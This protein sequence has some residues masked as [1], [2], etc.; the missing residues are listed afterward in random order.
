MASTATS[1]IYFFEFVWLFLLQVANCCIEPEDFC[2]N[3]A[4]ECTNSSIIERNVSIYC[5]GLGACAESSITHIGN[6]DSG[7]TGCW[8]KR[9]CQSVPILNS[10]VKHPS[11][12]RGFLSFAW[13]K[14][15]VVGSLQCYGEASCYQVENCQSKYVYCQGLRGCDGLFSVDSVEVRANGVL[16]LQHSIF[17]NPP[18]VKLHG[19][20]SGYN[21]T[22][23]CES[24]QTCQITCHVNGCSNLNLICD[25]GANCMVDCN[26][27]KGITCPTRWDY[28]FIIS[29]SDFNDSVG[30]SIGYGYSL[31]NS[32]SDSDR[33]SGSY[34]NGNDSLY[35]VLEY[36]SQ[37]FVDKTNN[38]NDNDEYI[39]NNNLYIENK[40]SNNECDENNAQDLVCNNKSS[41]SGYDISNKAN[42]CCNGEAACSYSKIMEFDTL[43]CDSS[44]GCGHEIIVGKKNMINGNYTSDI[45]LRA[46]WAAWEAHISNFYRIFA[47]ATQAAAE[48]NI[49][50]G[51][52]LGCVGIESCEYA[53]ISG[54]KTIYGAGYRALKNSI[55]TSGGI[56]SMFVY[57]L[58]YESGLDINITCTNGDTCYIMCSNYD[59]CFNLDNGA[60]GCSGEGCQII[61]VDLSSGTSYNYYTTTSVLPNTTIDTEIT[62]TEMRTKTTMT[63]T[64]TTE[65]PTVPTTSTTS[66]NIASTTQR[67]A[68]KSSKNK[69]NS[70]QNLTVM[71][72]VFVLIKFFICQDHS[73][74]FGVLFFY[75]FFC[76]FCVIFVAG[77][78]KTVTHV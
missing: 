74:F 61:F 67:A 62:T 24:D 52:H 36:L 57:L 25:D 55:I 34:N 51:E 14:L 13:S 22:I 28:D 64:Q 43:Y 30:I 59:E 37:V 42:I 19:F 21:A 77:R 17:I 70:G 29:L 50:D 1:I 11:D 20:Y 66:I 18:L 73:T 65:T 45:Y 27:T 6:K 35:T 68:K 3:D 15:A 76:F 5:N 33:T 9:S 39:L 56:G 53:T 41:C 60:I 32:P 16:S 12:F 71:F 44:T 38:N 48:T 8:G 58:G 47:S 54:V 31:S 72:I 75:A 78:V 63:T 46:R 2:C 40:Y 7:A 4:F 69:S 26:E 49:S 10:S 23:Y